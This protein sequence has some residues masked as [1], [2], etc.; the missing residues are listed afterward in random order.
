MARVRVDYLRAR[1]NRVR[2]AMGWPETGTYNTIGYVFLEKAYRGWRVNQIVNERGGQREL[3]GHGCMLSAREL[4]M[5]FS[6]V[7]YA[8]CGER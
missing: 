1:F 8:K 2:E 4:D 6:G 3:T 5:W 7:L